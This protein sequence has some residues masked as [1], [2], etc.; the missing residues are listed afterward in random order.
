MSIVAAASLKSQWRNQIFRR[1]GRDRTAVRKNLVA[2]SLVDRSNLRAPFVEIGSLLVFVLYEDEIL[3][4]DVTRMR[5]DPLRFAAYRASRVPHG[6]AWGG[7]GNAALYKDLTLSPKPNGRG[8]RIDACKP[9]L[10]QMALDLNSHLS[11]AARH[12]GLR[13]PKL[14]L[15]RLWAGFRVRDV[16]Q[17][18]GEGP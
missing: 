5:R 4:P 8:Q 18:H 3:R 9:E 12:P 11:R 15:P 6:V 13:R 17:L 14:R 1:R 7:A 10:L 16:G 2:I